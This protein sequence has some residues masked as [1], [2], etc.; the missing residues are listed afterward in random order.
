MIKNKRANRLRVR[1]HLDDLAVVSAYVERR[2]SELGVNP[3]TITEVQIAVDEAITNVIQHSYCPGQRG[4]IEISCEMLGNH[5]RVTIRDDG[6]PFDPT[7]YQCD[8][9]TESE[10]EMRNEG[11]LGI[12]FMRQLMDDLQYEY[13]EHEGLTTL[14]MLK[15]VAPMMSTAS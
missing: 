7:V 10:L 1:N 2:L 12:Y 11:G 4:K 15:Q 3:G 8:P 9:D 14:T 13:S 5:L 6:K